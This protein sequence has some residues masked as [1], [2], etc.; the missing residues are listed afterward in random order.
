MPHPRGTIEVK[1]VRDHGLT[2]DIALPA[3][4]DGEFDWNGLSHALHTG[5][6][7]L[8]IQ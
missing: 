4:T 3:A 7:H 2:A 8:E 6:N 1:L 5:S